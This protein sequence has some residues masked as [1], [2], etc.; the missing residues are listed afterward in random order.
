[1]QLFDLNI[2]F[3]RCSYAAQKEIAS[4]TDWYLVILSSKTFVFELYM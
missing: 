1:M 2:L 3:F 4:Q